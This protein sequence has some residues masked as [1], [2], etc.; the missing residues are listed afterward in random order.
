MRARKRS[1]FTLIELLVALVIAGILG[2][3]LLQFLRSQGRLAE[4]QGARHEVQQNAR[5]AVAVITGDL[6]GVGPRGITGS[7]TNSIDLRVPYVWGVVCDVDDEDLVVLFP[8]DVW[9]P[10]SG[11][12]GDGGGGLL[13]GL[14][15]VGGGNDGGSKL[16]A[17][18]MIDAGDGWLSS[19]IEVRMDGPGGGAVG[20][21]NSQLGLSPA[22][23]PNVSDEESR[24]RTIEAEDEDDVEDVD[25][26]A[27]LYLY[28]PVRYEVRE[29]DGL[30]GHWIVRNSQPLAGPVDGARGLRFTYL[31][32]NGDPTGDDDD[33]RTIRVRVVTHSRAEFN[34]QPREN[35]VSTEVYLR[36]RN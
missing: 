31:D 22:L 18:A 33:V 3:V 2:T 19:K 32:G 26:G 27:L 7:G 23:D 16:D 10:F 36:N 11:G 5:S 14:P 1:G 28:E 4:L 13:G 9:P 35:D 6:R 12:G 30:S 25:V 17:S 20:Q 21:C 29:V 34:E 24:V 15:L 8:P